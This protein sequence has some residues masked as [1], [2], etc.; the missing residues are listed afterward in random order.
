MHNEQSVFALIKE[1][2]NMQWAFYFRTCLSN[3]CLSTSAVMCFVDIACVM[4]DQVTIYS[5][6]VKWIKQ[7]IFY[8]F[9]MHREHK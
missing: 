4:P 1:P 5:Y 8:I 7:S 9:E 3:V 6:Y 2:P